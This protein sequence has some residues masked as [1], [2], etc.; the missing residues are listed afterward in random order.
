M[1]ASTQESRCAVERCVIMGL[2]LSLFLIWHPH[3]SGSIW[4]GFYLWP[5]NGK[6][7]FSHLQANLNWTPTRIEE[8]YSLHRNCCSM[9][10]QVT[11]VFISWEPKYRSRNCRTKVFQ[12]ETQCNL[13]REQHCDIVFLEVIMCPYSTWKNSSMERQDEDFSNNHDVESLS[14]QGT[15]L[16][17]VR[18]TC[19]TKKSL[20]ACTK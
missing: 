4:K 16:Q 2:M 3:F 19:Y 5:E 18:M 7:I 11:R 12:R 6:D 15:H 1:G 14:L 8:P 17:S 9:W 20:L 10:K 13:S